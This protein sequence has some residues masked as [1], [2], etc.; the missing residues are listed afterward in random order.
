M[1]L[2]PG[3]GRCSRAA[4]QRER[5]DGHKLQGAGSRKKRRRGRSSRGAAVTG[6]RRGKGEREKGW[7]LAGHRE[8]AGGEVPGQLQA[9]GCG[10]R[11]EGRGRGREVQVASLS[12]GKEREWPAGFA[13]KESP[14]LQQ[15]TGWAGEDDGRAVQGSWKEGEADGFSWARVR[16]F[17]ESL[18][19]QSIEEEFM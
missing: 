16:N 11:Q 5:D 1:A 12:A 15:G 7:C 3:D 14:L 2:Q 13:G 19:S 10:R 8:L 9:A 17:V 6:Q 4:G 18:F